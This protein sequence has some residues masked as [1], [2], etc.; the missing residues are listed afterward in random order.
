MQHRY[1]IALAAAAALLAGQATVQAAPKDHPRDQCFRTSD[2]DSSV[3]ATQTQLNLKLRDHRYYQIQTKG[4]CFT[5]LGADPYVLKIHGGID[6]VCHPI[7]LDL[8]AGPRGFQTP[9]IVDKITPM[10]KEQVL[11]LPKRQRP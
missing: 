8:S 7:D 11:A 4:V 9:C 5:T 3:Q 2:I 10:T 1:S 6:L